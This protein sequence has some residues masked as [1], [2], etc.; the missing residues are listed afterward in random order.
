[1]AEKQIDAERDQHERILGLELLAWKWMIAHDRLKSGAEYDLPRT[2]DMP[3][4]VSLVETLKEAVECAC[5]IGEDYEGM[6]WNNRVDKL[7][8]ALEAAKAEGF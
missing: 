6:I 2:T 4:L 1:M 8:K 3:R 7:L 5:G